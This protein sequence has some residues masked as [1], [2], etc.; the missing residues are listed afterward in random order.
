MAELKAARK[1]TFDMT[2]VK[3]R[4]P[5]NP[6]HVEP[7]DYRLKITAV[8]ETESKKSGEAMW[9]FAFQLTEK[10]SA[11]YP[12]YCLLNEDNLWKIRNV[13]EAAGISVPK[14]RVTLDPAKLIGREIGATLE[15]DEYE[16]KM[17]SVVN[18]IFS[19][20][21]LEDVDSDS[22]EDEEDTTDVEDEEDEEEEEEPPAPKKKS[23]KEASSK[24]AKKV[25]QDDDEDDEE[26]D[27]DDLEELDVDEL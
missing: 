22:D 19:A 3:E 1:K 17:K 21:E 23:S 12:Y 25:T 11:V 20:S 4:G 16:G 10:A 18:S 14:K 15:E 6:V 13:C 5:F 8:Y 24:K 7:G 2:K 27:D 26:V 9:V